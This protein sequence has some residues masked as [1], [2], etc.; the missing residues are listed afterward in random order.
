MA[1]ESLTEDQARELL[2][3]ACLPAA[4]SEQYA[5]RRTDEGWYFFWRTEAGQSLIGT[6][7]WIVSY[8]GKC[9]G[10]PAGASVHIPFELSD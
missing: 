10:S 5:A 6:I 9:S 4:N 2:A 7:G 8:D 3:N 1:S